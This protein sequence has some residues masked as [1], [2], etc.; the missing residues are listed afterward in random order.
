MY[1]LEKVCGERYIQPQV[2]REDLPQA[3]ETKPKR[4][5]ISTAIA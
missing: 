5:T 1:Q 3:K 4:S 2:D